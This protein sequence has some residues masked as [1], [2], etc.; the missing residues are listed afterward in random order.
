MSRTLILIRH[1]KSDWGDP[2]LDDYDRP[3]NDR[4]R[5]SARAVGDWLAG[6]GEVPDACLLSGAR[7]TV[8]TWDILSTAFEHPA[9]ARLD[10]RLY[11][12]SR[13]TILDV[14][15]KADG[16]V[17]AL[18]GHNPGIGDFAG[19]IVGQPP[20][21]PRFADYPTCATTVMRFEAPSWAGI[22]WGTGAVAAFTVPRDLV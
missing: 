19:A 12:A 15:R 8:E 21:H 10:R 4:G 17:V 11:H 7:R 18:V 5:R 6:L 2:R 1:A 3:L 9:Q 13:E 20:A 14:L 22:S 16:R